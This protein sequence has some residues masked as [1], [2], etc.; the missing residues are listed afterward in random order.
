MNCDSGVSQWAY[1][2]CLFILV[3]GLVINIPHVL[4]SQA[5]IVFVYFAFLWLALFGF[6]SLRRS[7]VFVSL[8]LRSRV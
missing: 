8:C 6:P 5:A 1:M 7:N 3:L 2:F 4:F